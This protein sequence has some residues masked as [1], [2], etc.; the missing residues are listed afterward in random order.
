M[1]PV[2]FVAR[3]P[4]GRIYSTARRVHA[5][6]VDGS[7]R[8]RLEAFAHFFQDVATDD[9]ADAGVE[10]R[11]GVWMMRR[12]EVEIAHSPRFGDEVILETFASGTG[13]R[14]GERRTTM[15]AVGTRGAGGV[16]AECA[17]VWVFVDP[18]RGKLLPLPAEFD[19]VYGPSAGDRRISGRLVHP[20]PHADAVSR[21]WPLRECDFDVLDHVNNARYLEAVEDELAARTPGHRVVHASVEY[22]GAVERGE[23]VNLVSE[24]RGLGPGTAEL[25]AWLLV[26]GIVR[27]S[28]LVTTV[29]PD[30]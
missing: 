7:A 6:D 30:R 29:G 3:P 21:P 25:A 8:L 4:R 19:A 22:R 20:K 16:L 15:R 5:G 14:W 23:E 24:Q 9:V 1:V 26:G 10:S 12:I 18:V 17:A 27:V 13:P 11:V 28:A 2:E